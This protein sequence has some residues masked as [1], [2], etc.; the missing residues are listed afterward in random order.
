MGSTVVHVG[1]YD[2]SPASLS[3]LAALALYEAVLAFLPD[4]RGLQL[5]WPNDVM[6]G[7]DKLSGI[8]LERVGDCAVI[9]IGVNLARAPL[10]ADRSVGSLSQVTSAPGRDAFARVLAGHFESELAVWRAQGLSPLLARWQAAAHPIGT[11]LNVHDATGERI[12]GT[13]AGLG[14]DGSLQLR[15]PDGSVRAIH[16]GDVT[17]EGA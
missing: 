9:G 17:L 5:K 13:F 6:L 1:A 3:F 11:P 8:L 14:S 12:A 16:A 4:P 2:P 15:L 10:V 7:G